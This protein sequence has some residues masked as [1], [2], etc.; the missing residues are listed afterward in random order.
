[1]DPF[2]EENESMT[3]AKVDSKVQPTLESKYE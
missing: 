3:K 1:M 2:I